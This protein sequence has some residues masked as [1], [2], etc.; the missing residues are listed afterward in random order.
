MDFHVWSY[1]RQRFIEIRSG[2]LEPQRVEVW[3]F[4]LL[5]LMAFTTVCTTVQA[6]ITFRVS[7]RRRE[8][9]SGH[10]RLC[11]CLPVCLSLPHSHT[12]ART[13]M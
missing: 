3:P 11:V 10:A 2:I 6:V 9:Y 1:P 12:T 5:W 4:P 13:R 8:M 7:R